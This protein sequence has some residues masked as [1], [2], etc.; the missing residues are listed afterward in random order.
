MGAMA[1]L[2]PIIAEIRA[3]T[4]VRLIERSGKVA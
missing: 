2:D 3:K 4:P 1:H